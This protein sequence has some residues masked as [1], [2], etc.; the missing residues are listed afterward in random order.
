MP[1]A[2]VAERDID[3]T[4]LT[5]LLPKWGR[6]MFDAELLGDTDRPVPTLTFRPLEA[7]MMAHYI[8][9]LLAFR[10]AEVIQ[11]EREDTGDWLFGD[12]H[13]I[14]VTGM[15]VFVRAIHPTHAGIPDDESDEMTEREDATLLSV[16]E[17]IEDLIWRADML[18]GAIV[19]LLKSSPDCPA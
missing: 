2:T 8:N 5:Q 18:D 12:H 15:F 14:S 4:E 17:F 9:T 3:I 10:T 11:W 1:E 19:G 16:C 7:P 13:R 6:L